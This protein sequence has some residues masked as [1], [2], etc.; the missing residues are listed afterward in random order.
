MYQ[1]RLYLEFPKDALFPFCVRPWGF[2]TP[3]APLTPTPPHTLSDPRLPL[4]SF[5]VPTVCDDENDEKMGFGY[6]VSQG[7][8]PC[9]WSSSTTVPHVLRAL[10]SWWFTKALEGRQLETCK[11]RL[12]QLV[13]HSEE[14]VGNRDLDAE[15]AAYLRRLVDDVCIAGGNDEATMQLCADAQRLLASDLCSMN[16]T[17]VRVVHKL[18]RERPFCDYHM[19]CT[20]E[21]LAIAREFIPATC[22]SIV[23]L[24]W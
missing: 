19:R 15:R 10:R 6:Y 17:M 24:Y 23:G 1:S 9:D 3:D 16:C 2:H 21:M 7:E 5:C 14:V 18:N 13:K 12:K 22:V 8:K 20:T 4:G 11:S